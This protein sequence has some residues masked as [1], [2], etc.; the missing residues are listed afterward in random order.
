MPKSVTSKNDVVYKATEVEAL[1]A[2][3]SAI[4]FRVTLRRELESALALRER[5]QNDLA[6]TNNL[7]AELETKIDRSQNAINN[8]QQMCKDNGLIL[9]FTTTL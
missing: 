6:K 7:C 8:A 9:F 1:N 5:Q 3:Q 4:E 2:F